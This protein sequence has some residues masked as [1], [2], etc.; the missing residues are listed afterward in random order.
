M[1]AMHYCNDITMGPNVKSVLQSIYHT[2]EGG[3]NKV[4]DG[5]IFNMYIFGRSNLG[6]VDMSFVCGFCRESTFCGLHI[7]YLSASVK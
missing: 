6:V 5:V 2:S 3:S 4:Y 1:K 7:E